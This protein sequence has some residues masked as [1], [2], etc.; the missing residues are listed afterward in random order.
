MSLQSADMTRPLVQPMAASDAVAWN[1]YVTRHPRGSFFHLAE[2]AG[3]THD[4][5]GHR[6]HFL[7][8]RRGDAICGLLPLIEIRTLLFGH[9][10]VSNAFTVGGGPLADDRQVEQALLDEAERLYHRLALDRIE[11]RGPIE[12]RRGWISENTTYAGFVQE[13]D[14]DIDA[15]LAR[16]RR[17]QRAMVRK[18]QKFDLKVRIERDATSFLPLYA[19]SLHRHG[20]PMLHNGFYSA[21]IERFGEAC[22]V[23]LIEQDG[24][25]VAGVMSFYFNGMVMPYYA[26]S[27]T[28]ARACAAHDLMYFELMR[29]ALENKGC[30]WFDFGRSKAGTGSYDFKRHWGFTPQP[31]SY[32]FRLPDGEALPEINPLNPKFQRKVAIWRKLPNGVVSRLGPWIARQLG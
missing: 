10:L 7:I 14:P 1:A 13:L 31:L 30:T 5:L 3:I 19:D 17:K 6:S 21:L 15:N 18:A 22:D 11:I 28:D 4:V 32:S 24:T 27:T 9:A 29:H 16:I 26:G 23:L 2:W 25:P 12:E 20:T 8:A